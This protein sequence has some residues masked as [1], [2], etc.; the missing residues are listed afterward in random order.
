MTT[1]LLLGEVVTPLGSGANSTVIGGNL[2]QFVS[3]LLRTGIS[4]DVDQ[5]TS[6]RRKRSGTI[7]VAEQYHRYRPLY[8][9]ALISHLAKIVGEVPEAD[10]VVDVG[11]GTGIFSRQL[12]AALHD[13]MTIIGIEP[14][15]SMRAQA[16]AEDHRCHG[17]RIQGRRR[18]AL[19]FCHRIGAGG[20]R[21]D[22]SALVRAPDI[23]RRRVPHPG[24]GRHSRDRRICPR[25]GGQPD[26]RRADRVH[27]PVRFGEGVCAA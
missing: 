15:P 11:A 24:S 19:A 27:E 26:R 9:D 4:A 14:S 18:G 8:P 23:L 10:V 5:E 12:R 22:H 6:W 3:M 20:C 2:A 21:G 25:P 13:T 16:V 1:F 7:W 17:S